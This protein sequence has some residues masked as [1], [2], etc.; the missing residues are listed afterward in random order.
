LKKIHE[1]FL[2]L[3][4]YDF[5]ESLTDFGTVSSLQLAPELW[6]YAAQIAN[7]LRYR[8][9]GIWAQDL[10]KNFQVNVI[11]E[12]CGSYILLRTFI[13]KNKPHI[14]SFTPFFPAANRLERHT[15][16]MFGVDFIGH[17]DK[18][19]WTRHLA[20]NEKQFPLCKQF[21]FTKNL[22][23]ITPP[24]NSYPFTHVYGTG[25]FEIPVGPIHAGIIEPGHFRFHAAGENIITLEERLAYK[26]K[27]IEKIAE[28]RDVSKL[29]KLAGRVSG[30]STVAYAWSACRAIESA[31]NL[32][33]TKRAS[34]MRAIMCE[35]ERI[36]NHLGDF[37]G[38]A[39]DVAYT[40]GYYQLMR[41][42][43]HWLRLN[44]ELFGHR[45]MM[46][47]VVPGGV[48]V[49]LSSD[50][51]QAMLEQIIDFRSELVDLYQIFEE[52]SGFHDRL[53][54]TGIL[55]MELSLQL[56]ALGF[57][58]RA[59]GS[60]FD[61]RRDVPYA[62]Y[63]ELE[64]DVPVFHNGDVLARV[65]VRAQ[66]VLVSFDLITHLLYLLS[67]SEQLLLKENYERHFKLENTVEGIG[68]V[69]GWRGEILTF[70]KLGSDGLVER[71]FPRDPSWFSWPALEQLIYGNIVPD[72]PVC[73]KSINGSY[74][75]VDL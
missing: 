48:C 61:M 17:P 49:N 2:Q 3:L 57:V 24:D 64:V 69:E 15:H 36:A 60:K 9:V 39:N 31:I 72:F 4:N 71:Y 66:E 14:A 11:L 45:F 59:S 62:P 16:D 21:S 65:R 27:G 7:Q 75:A 20:W 74:S 18:R 8:F 1:Q 53:K 46:D 6:R 13:V 42:K 68:L 30:D 56:G 12:L 26:H 22:K 43:E 34:I 70:V 52:N 28:G 50:D 73:N 5:V 58:G 41:L 55:S 32:E 63:D 19:R 37:A 51:C 29:V 33:V 40:F 23:A 38:I 10:N 44:A 54:A 47:C 67:K 25:V 35:R